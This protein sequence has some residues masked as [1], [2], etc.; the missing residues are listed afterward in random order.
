MEYVALP[1]PTPG[2]P[3]GRRLLSGPPR[4]W[5]ILRRGVLA[6]M[7]PAPVVSPGPPLSDADGP[8]LVLAAGSR[9]RRLPLDTLRV[10]S[11]ER[12]CSLRLNRLRGS[13]PHLR[14]CECLGR[15]VSSWRARSAGVTDHNVR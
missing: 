14:V 4:N 11:W 13:L 1:P 6:L 12:R 8:V 5:L 2:P 15:S 3:L 9:S 7:R 10:W